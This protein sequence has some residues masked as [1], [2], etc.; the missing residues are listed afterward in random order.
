MKEISKT[1]KGKRKKNRLN[2]F[3]PL[4]GGLRACADTKENWGFITLNTNCCIS[5]AEYTFNYGWRHVE[6]PSPDS[7]RK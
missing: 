4:D 6:R 2:I 1:M 7:T 5:L 3:F